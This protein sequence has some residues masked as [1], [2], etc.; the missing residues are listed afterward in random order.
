MPNASTHEPSIP[1]CDQTSYYQTQ[2]DVDIAAAVD[3]RVGPYAQLGLRL[4]GVML[5]IQ[6]IGNMIGSLAQSAVYATQLKQAGYALSV[7]AYAFGWF[8]SSLVLAGAG[9]YLIIG[10]RWIVEKIF[11]PAST[12]KQVDDGVGEAVHSRSSESEPDNSDYR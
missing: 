10:G 5:L 12:S 2:E 7:D 1:P 9:W 4:L 11:L 8:I 3:Q 6:G